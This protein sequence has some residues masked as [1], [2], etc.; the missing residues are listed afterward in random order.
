[1]ITFSFLWHVRCTCKVRGA[2]ENIHLNLQFTWSLQSILASFSSV[3][4]I[5]YVSFKRAIECTWPL[6]S[7]SEDVASVH[8]ALV[9]EDTASVQ[10][11]LAVEAHILFFT[12]GTHSRGHSLCT[13]DPCCRGHSLCT[14]DACCPGCSLFT[15]DAGSGGHSLCKWVYSLRLSCQTNK[16]KNTF[17]M[18]LNAIKFLST[19]TGLSGLGKLIRVRHFVCMTQNKI[20]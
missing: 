5:I 2:A 15:R 13:Q 17:V 8:E 10:R 9:L 16:Q 18:K 19:V 3:G 14:V 1:M 12:K 20:K 4:V 6:G 7:F 11:L